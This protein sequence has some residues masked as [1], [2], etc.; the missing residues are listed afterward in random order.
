MVVGGGI[1]GCAT[2]YH[3]AKSGCRDVVLIERAKLTSGSTWHAAGAVA[4]YRSNANL[5]YLIAYGVD[6]YSKLEAETG[7]ATGWRQLGGM[8]LTT[9]KDRRK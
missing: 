6:L 5:M 1:M 7:Q 8:R 4:Q 2:A 9:S 3:L